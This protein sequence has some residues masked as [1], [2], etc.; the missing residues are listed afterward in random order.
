MI[1]S[2]V[3]F[4]FSLENNCLKMVRRIIYQTLCGKGLRFNLE[5]NNKFLQ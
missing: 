1:Q 4:Q 2:V 5:K 3:G